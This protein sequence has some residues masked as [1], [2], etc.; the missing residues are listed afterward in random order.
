MIQFFY[1]IIFFAV[2]AVFLSYNGTPI[3]FVILRK[4]LKNLK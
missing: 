1:Y 3:S 2:S 4:H